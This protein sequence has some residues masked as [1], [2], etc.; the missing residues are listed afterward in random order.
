MSTIRADIITVI[1]TAITA[2]SFTYITQVFDAGST[3]HALS[4]EG[5]S[6][7][8]FGDNYHGVGLGDTRIEQ[9]NYLG[10]YN[11]LLVYADLVIYGKGTGRDNL[12]ASARELTQLFT[13][14]A[15]NAKTITSKMDD[16]SEA[17]DYADG[18]TIRCVIATLEVVLYEEGALS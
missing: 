8:V 13:H 16:V 4:G 11:R 10:N 6:L 5:I 17:I 14:N 15:I 18:L 9:P 1:Q 2:E 3:D 7:P 12:T